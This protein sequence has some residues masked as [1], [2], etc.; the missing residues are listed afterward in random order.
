MSSRKLKL[1]S[2]PSRAPFCVFV[3]KSSQACQTWRE[4][5]QIACID[6]SKVCGLRQFDSPPDVAGDSHA[7]QWWNMRLDPK[8]ALFAG[9]VVIVS[10]DEVQLMVEVNGKLACRTTHGAPVDTRQPLG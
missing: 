4:S 6:V 5:L 7:H 3:E 1:S 8:K 9:W 2:K 10:Q